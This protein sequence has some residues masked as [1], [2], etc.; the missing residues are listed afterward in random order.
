M[1]EFLTLQVQV[2]YIW[3]QVIDQLN[4]RFRQHGGGYQYEACECVSSKIDK[5]VLMKIILFPLVW[6]YVWFSRRLIRVYTVLILVGTMT[7]FALLGSNIGMTVGGIA[8]VGY[9]YFAREKE[10]KKVSETVYAINTMTEIPEADIATDKAG[11]TL[12]L[13]NQILMIPEGQGSKSTLVPLETTLHEIEYKAEVLKGNYPMSLYRDV[14][15]DDGMQRERKTLRIGCVYS[16]SK[17]T[18]TI[19]PKHIARFLRYDS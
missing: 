3:E 4:R 1:G 9:Y 13:Y 8:S 6:I 15:T 11:R 7:V 12:M 10:K 16:F 19:S 14:Q 17:C 5:E 18:W 2:L